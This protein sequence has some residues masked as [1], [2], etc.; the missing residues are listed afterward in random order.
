VTDQTDAFSSDD[1]FCHSVA[2]PRPFRVAFIQEEVLRFADGGDMTVVQPRR[3]SRLDVERDAR[4]AGYCAPSDVGGLTEDWGT[5]DFLL[6]VY[7]VRS[8]GPQLLAEGR[9]TLAE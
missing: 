7:R 2:V 9:F 3:E 5:G 6:R 8:G 1:R 4:V